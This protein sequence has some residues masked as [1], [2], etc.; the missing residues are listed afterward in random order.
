[1]LATIGMMDSA[2]A[3]EALT[4]ILNGFQMEASGASD[5]VDKLLKVD[6]IAATSSEELATS[7]QYVSSMARNAGITLDQM[8]G[9]I[10]VGSE[11]TRTSAETIGNAWKSILTRMQQVK[12]G[13]DVDDMGEPLEIF[14][15]L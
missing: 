12:A 2:E 7:L 9:I 11:T 14:G 5:V 6:L 15:A 4:A 8:I 1:M 3:T 10:A 13:V